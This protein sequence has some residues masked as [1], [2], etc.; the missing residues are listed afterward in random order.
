MARARSS[1]PFT[2]DVVESIEPLCAVVDGVEFVVRRG[3]A[4]R[5]DSPVV[6]HHP[7]LF[8]DLGLGQT[9][10]RYQPPAAA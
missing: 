10:P 7:E 5:T 8:V 1:N 6:R 9:T 4:W 2:A 3:T